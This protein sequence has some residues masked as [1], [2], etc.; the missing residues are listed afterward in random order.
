MIPDLNPCS[1]RGCYLKGSTCFAGYRRSALGP[2]P[3]LQGDGARRNP[4]RNQ[5]VH[6]GS[7]SQTAAIT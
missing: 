4:I 3:S 1:I 6:P 5:Q 7:Q 2:G